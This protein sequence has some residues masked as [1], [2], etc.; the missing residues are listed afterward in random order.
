MHAI[1]RSDFA[2]PD[3]G[4]TDSV[5]RITAPLYRW[6]H[7]DDFAANV[8][9]KRHRSSLASATNP[10]GPA[11][12][13]ALIYHRPTSQLPMPD[14][15]CRKLIGTPFEL[16]SLPSAHNNCQ[17]QA[18]ERA[19]LVIKTCLQANWEPSTVAR[20]NSVLEGAVVEAEAL[21]G[22][23]LLPCDSDVKL[24]LLFARYDGAC[25]GSVS[26]AKSAV[27]AWHLERG[28]NGVFQLAWTERASLFWKV[29]KKEETTP[30]VPLSARSITRNS[31][32]SR[33]HE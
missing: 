10:G 12:V 9:T 21:M 24:M 1:R 19:A 29:L 4:G 11:P 32:A 16:L 20:Y 27:R 33:K 31:S 18:R 3:E 25:W 22:I 23:E 13:S 7:S 28:L 6:L 17:V 14:S 8:D 15:S 26:A 2:R 30:K 5:T